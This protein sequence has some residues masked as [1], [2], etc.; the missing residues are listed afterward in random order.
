M[1]PRSG[2]GSGPENHRITERVSRQLILSLIS[3][4]MSGS[5]LTTVNRCQSA[6]WVR[7]S[8]LT[9]IPPRQAVPSITENET[10]VSF[11]NRDSYEIFKLNPEVLPNSHHL[12]GVLYLYSDSM[13]MLNFIRPFG[14]TLYATT[15]NGG[16]VYNTVWQIQG[17]KKWI[18]IRVLQPVSFD[19][20]VG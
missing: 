18:Y 11:F 17:S 8:A 12:M 6:A 16:S 19:D 5:F 3:T 20:D 2:L 14:R 10:E 9:F 4:T 1:E 13:G 15:S 7:Q